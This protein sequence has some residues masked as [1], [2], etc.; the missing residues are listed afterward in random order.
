MPD[1]ARRLAVAR[2]DELAD[3]V[4]EGGEGLLRLHARVARDRDRDLRRLRRRPRRVRGQ[5]GRAR[6]R[7]IRRPRASSTR[8]CTWRRRSSSW[9][10]SRA[11]SSRSG[12]RRSSPTRTRSRTSS[13]RTGSTGSPTSPTRSRSTSSSWPRRAVPASKF[14]SPRRALTLGDLQGL[15]HRRRVIGLAEMMNYPGVVSG[16][17][18]ELAKLALESLARGRAR[19]RRPRARSC[20]PTRPPGSAPTTS[21]LDP[22]EGRE[23]LRA[24]MWVLIREATAARNLEALAPLVDEF[25]PAPPGPLHRR[26]RARAH[27]R[28][29]AHEPVV[30][31]AVELGHLAR[32][33]ARHGDAQPA[34]LA[35]PAGLRRHRARLQSPTCSSCPDLE[36]FEPERRAEARRA[37][38]GLPEPRRCPSGCGTP[39]ASQPVASNDFAIPWEGGAARVIGLVEGQIVTDDAARGAERRGRACGRGSRARLPRSPSSSGISGRG[40]SGS[41]S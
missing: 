26:P 20:R 41:A 25:G 6:A 35:R 16:D 8:T 30:R 19:A 24:G 22:E 21:A 18:H 10:S 28:G 17:P 5:G 23:R 15:L 1:L 29:G 12:R 38:G 27:R 14:E 9:T 11:S 13:A 39:C 37:G 40:G 3:V 34:T 33:R 4:I 36:R 32:G 7:Q 31:S 2:G